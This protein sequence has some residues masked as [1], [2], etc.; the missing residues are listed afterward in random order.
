MRHQP[1]FKGLE[2]ASLAR[3]AEA[4]VRRNLPRSDVLFRRGDLPAGM[5]VVVFGSIQLLAPHGV[6]GKRLTG[7]VRAGQSFGEPVM[8]LQRPAMVDAVA[9]EDSLVVQ[10]P[11][12]ALLALVDENPL[13]A[14]QLLATLSE[15]V[16]KLVN[17]LARQ[18]G[19]SG[20]ARLASYLLAHSG[21]A[22][23]GELALPASKA[24]V[25]SQLNV[26]P[27]H[28]SRLLHELAADGVLAIE[29]RRV[30]VLDRDRLA[31]AAGT[32]RRRRAQ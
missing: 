26:T 3:L 18:S 4:A 6:R 16:E 10:L 20:R 28:F 17:E 27:E 11:R 29:G 1:L 9:A 13:L 15:R 19:G 21:A 24:S 23:A 8:F 5:Y 31:A 7:V 25:A 12:E 32:H 14:R 22:G 30:R 2:P